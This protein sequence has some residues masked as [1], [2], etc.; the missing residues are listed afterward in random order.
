M[1]IQIMMGTY[2]KFEKKMNLTL[3]Y[4]D[5]IKEK[6]MAFITDATSE[7]KRVYETNVRYPDIA[8]TILQSAFSY[9][10]FENRHEVNIKDIRKAIKTTKLVYPDVITKEL[11]KFNKDFKDVYLMETKQILKGEA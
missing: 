1:V 5:F 8:L 11:V 9:A 3:K 2:P 10:A 4:S 7:F 6:I